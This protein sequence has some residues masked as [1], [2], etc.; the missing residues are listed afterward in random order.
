MRRFLLKNPQ[1]PSA[2]TGEIDFRP[3]MTHAF[4]G[5]AGIGA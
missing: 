1:A 3:I 4:W 2:S 5:L